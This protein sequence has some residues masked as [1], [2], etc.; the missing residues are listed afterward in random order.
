VPGLWKGALTSGKVGYFDP[1]NT[2][3]FIE[4]KS[5]PDGGTPKKSIT[6]KG[7]SSRKLGRLY[8]PE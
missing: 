2:V 4:P 7:K 3:P 5:S 8:F 6:R 1:C